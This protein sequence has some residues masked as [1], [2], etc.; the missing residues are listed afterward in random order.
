MHFNYW[1]SAVKVADYERGIVSRICLMFFTTFALK[2]NGPNRW[3][4]IDGQINLSM[5]VEALN[6]TEDCL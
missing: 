3:L 5:P 2:C 1:P 6:Y 4:K